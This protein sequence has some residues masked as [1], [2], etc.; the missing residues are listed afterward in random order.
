MIRVIALDSGPLGQRTGPPQSRITQAINAWTATIVTAGHRIVVPSIA[1]YEVR[2]EL[3]RLGKASGIARLDAFNL[4]YPDR[5]IAV[6]N[7]TLTL[8]AKLWAKARNA[9]T[10]T[11]DPRE[12]DC[13][14]LIAAQALTM[15]IPESDLVIA[16]TNVG[17]LS[18]F[19]PAALWTDINP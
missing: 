5:L 3:V 17:H 12:L 2:R 14:V 15:G 9:V 6:W 10:P 11:G 18:K 4:A 8:G 13:D 7:T 19:A 16:T 1:D